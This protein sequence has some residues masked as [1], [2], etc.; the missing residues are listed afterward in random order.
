MSEKETTTASAL[1]T[2][3]SSNSTTVGTTVGG[4]NLATL[5]FL[6]WQAKGAFDE[7]FEQLDKTRVEFVQKTGELD[8]KISEL[9]KSV[10]TISPVPSTVAA[11]QAKVSQLEVEL[12]KLEAELEL[13]ED[14]AKDK[15][16]CP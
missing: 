10:D 9:A 11:L 15:R 8:Q 13:V 4:M 3:I 1:L 12:A 7:Q 16:K 6:G 2:K 5:L 14:C